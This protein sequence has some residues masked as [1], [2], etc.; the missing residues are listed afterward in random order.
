[1]SNAARLDPPMTVEEFQDWVPEPGLEGWRWQ[2]IDGTPVGMAPTSNAHGAIQSRTSTIIDVHLQK[3]GRCIVITTPGVI[4]KKRSRINQ[5]VPDLGVSCAG[6][7]MTDNTIRDPILLVEILSP[8]NEGITRGNVYAYQTI[9]SVQEI[10][11]L[12]SRKVAGT[13]HRRDGQGEWPDDPDELDAQ[14]TVELRCI[15]LKVALTAFYGS[16]GLVGPAPNEERA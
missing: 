11:V 10:L 14:S 5:L 13:L 8:S 12:D 2:L 3:L 15:G 4:P 16:S 1:M 6:Q 9:P 7:P